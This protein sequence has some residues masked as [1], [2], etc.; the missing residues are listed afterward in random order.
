MGSPQPQINPRV[1]IRCAE[2][3][4]FSDPHSAYLA[5]TCETL[6]CLGMDL[7]QCRAGA[8]YLPAGTVSVV[9]SSF[10]KLSPQLLLPSYEPLAVLRYMK[11]VPLLS[12]P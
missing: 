2:A 3:P 4:Q 1:E 6:D 10:M 8:K 12:G 5:I 9:G 11:F 7:Q